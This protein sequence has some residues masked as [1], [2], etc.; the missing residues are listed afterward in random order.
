MESSP[1]THGCVYEEGF[2]CE[3][4]FLAGSTRVR[5][6]GSSLSSGVI[7]RSLIPAR[8]KGSQANGRGKYGR[9]QVGI[10]AL[11]IQETLCGGLTARGLSSVTAMPFEVVYS[12]SASGTLSI[13]AELAA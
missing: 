7:G 13:R 6:V 12:L 2:L 11:G 5:Q 4:C 10:G 9:D 8:G 1:E 3:M